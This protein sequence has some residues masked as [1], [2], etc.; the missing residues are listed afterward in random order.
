MQSLI[1]V[2]IQVK[3]GTVMLGLPTSGLPIKII[4]NIKGPDILFEVEYLWNG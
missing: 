1:A 2:L 3:T 4:N